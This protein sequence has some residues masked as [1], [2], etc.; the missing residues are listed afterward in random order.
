ME[1][2]IYF[3]LWAGFFFLMMRFGCGAHV[4]GHG[5]GRQVA[6]ADN[7]D[8]TTAGPRWVPPPTDRDPVCGQTVDTA[9]A[10]S[11]VHDGWVYYFCSSTC[12]ERFEADPEAFLDAGAAPLPAQAEQ[13]HG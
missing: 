12:R 8:G 7:A 5:R 4:M 9:R 6:P 3:A 13:S 11:S 1:T 2:L 10:K